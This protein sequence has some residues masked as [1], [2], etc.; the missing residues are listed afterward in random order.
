MPVYEYVCEGCG[1]QVE[2]LLRTMTEKPLCPRCGGEDLEKLL[3][4]PS[5]P[6]SEKGGSLATV[7]P[8][9]DPSLPPCGPAC[10][11]WPG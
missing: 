3:S 10:R 5:A 9:C 8:S 2:L 11:R 7:N 6:R 1:S 4:V